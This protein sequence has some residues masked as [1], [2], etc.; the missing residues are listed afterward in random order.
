MIAKKLSTIL[1]ALLLLQWGCTG[2]MQ[3]IRAPKLDE[4]LA[5][6]QPIRLVTPLATV[7]TQYAVDDE[8]TMPP[9]KGAEL[10]AR[11]HK[12]LSR[13]I[14]AR[15]WSTAQ[16]IPM[17]WHNIA[18]G[19]E[20]TAEQTMQGDRQSQATL[21]IMRQL[22]EI[23]RHL[24]Y[25]ERIEGKLISDQ[26][27]A[28]ADTKILAEN[29]SLLFAMVIGCD[30]RI[31]HGPCRNIQSPPLRDNDRRFGLIR[32]IPAGMALHLYWV[33]AVT[34]Q[35]LWY[36]TTRN[37]NAVPSFAKNITSIVTDTLSEFPTPP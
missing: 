18:S 31:T 36:D 37:F 2:G 30:G 9:E 17:D 21:R 28:A 7:Y 11:T 4:Q 14:K 15:G 35:L 5:Q 22:E 24:R 8:P 29:G 27:V 33:D 12:E 25:N 20:I 6:T 26:W 34:G 32:T 3:A 16:S 19:H 23:G 1:L 13:Q 10:S